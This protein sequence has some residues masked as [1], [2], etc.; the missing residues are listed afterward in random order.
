MPRTRPPYPPEYRRRI[1][2]LAD[3]AE[4]L[5]EEINR[6]PTVRDVHAAIEMEESEIDA[7]IDLRS[8]VDREAR[9]PCSERP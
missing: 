4:H 5:R 3:A 9:T 6:E 7:V 2:E 8:R 1:V